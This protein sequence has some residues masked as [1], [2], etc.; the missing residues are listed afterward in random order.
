MNYSKI[1]VPLIIILL[2][3]FPFEFS[4]NRFVLA[5]ES[6][7]T[8]EHLKKKSE[9]DLT[10]L[11]NIKTAYSQNTSFLDIKDKTNSTQLLSNDLI[12]NDIK[13]K[14]WN[15]DS[16]KTEFNNSEMASHFKGKRVGIFGV[17]YGANC[18]GEVGK[19]T[20]CL[21]GGVTLH[22][23][24]KLD[25]KQS[26]G[27]NVFKDGTQQK[28][29]VITTEK[30]NPTIQEL[31]LKTRN[32]MQNQYKI[33]NSETGNIQKGYIEFHSVKS[34]FYYD[35]FDFKGKYFVDF[36]KFYNDNKTISSSNLHIDVYLYAQ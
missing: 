22:E 23:E 3:I 17:Y 8:T 29:F 21:Y 5:D 20:S 28:S 31:D 7:P 18:I 25:Q 36:L 27:V 33:Y 26:I 4:F 30:R 35:L 9:L 12:F 24:N 15:T 2:C 6:R 13:I 10:A 34:S 1:I 11:Y 19:R 32:V 16:L 14:E